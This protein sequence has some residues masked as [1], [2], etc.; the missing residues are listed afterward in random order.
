MWSDDKRWRVINT[1]EPRECYAALA[2]NAPIIAALARA[3]PAARVV[4]RPTPGAWSVIEV[5]NHLADE[6]REDFRTRLDY[7]RFRPGE[8][9][10]PIAPEHW[11]V[12]RAYQARDF[13][14]S[15]ARFLHERAQSLAWLEALDASDWTGTIRTPSGQSL[16]AGD[17]LTAW[18]AHDLLHARQLVELRYCSLAA[19][20]A[21]YDI[22]YAGPW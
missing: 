9:P 5:I 18:V 22:A 7:L 11:A 19:D 17:L 1:V 4:W 10:P 2:A 14:E 13:D 8:T 21:P 12:E 16:R 20:A 15:L 3:I 6:E